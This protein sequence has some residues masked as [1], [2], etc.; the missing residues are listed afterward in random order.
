M[1]RS[2]LLFASSTLIAFSSLAQNNLVFN[3][4]AAKTTIS[5]QIYGHFAEHL[6]HCVYGGF[7]VGEGNTKIPNS[8]GVRNDVI[9]ALK[10]LNSDR[11]NYLP[12]LDL[13]KVKED[14]TSWQ[15]TINN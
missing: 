10:K 7:Y 11:K 1:K 8:N 13:T 9:D 15:K 4:D 14:Y 2:A 3:V 5:R 12:R 6:G